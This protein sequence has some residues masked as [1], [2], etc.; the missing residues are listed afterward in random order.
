MKI[1]ILTDDKKFHRMLELE[2]TEQGFEVVDAENYTENTGCPVLCDLDCRDADWIREISQSSEIFGWTRHEIDENPLAQ[3]C[4]CVLE[5]PFLMSELREALQKYASGEKATRKTK[6]TQ[7]RVSEFGRR[8][9]MLTCNHQKREAVFGAHTI[10]L[11]PAEA[12]VLKLLCD[13]RGEVVSRASLTELFDSTEGNIAD[14]YIC[15]LRAKIDNNL[16]L[17]FI[18]TVKGKGYMLK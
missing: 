3:L 4:S 13:R 5:R 15:K 1:C 6:K 8:K 9:N 18:Y 10:A 2:L 17:K 14:V 11:S 16:G 7:N 12:D